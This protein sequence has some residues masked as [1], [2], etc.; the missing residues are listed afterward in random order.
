[1]GA[2]AISATFRTECLMKKPRKDREW[3][4]GA[5]VFAPTR[6]V[7]E[8][9]PLIPVNRPAV[10]ISYSGASEHV[11]VIRTLS[12]PSAIAVVSVSESLLRT[13]RGLLAPAIGRKHT[14]RETLMS[15]KVR[16][17]T[18]EFDVVFCDSIAFLSNQNKRKIRYQLVDDSCL[19]HLNASIKPR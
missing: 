7:G 14:F 12:K 11:A 9:Q 17:D 19:E 10:S 16:A 13:A 4:A 3:A 15:G 2:G 6:I 1:M 5:Q 18:S 8:L